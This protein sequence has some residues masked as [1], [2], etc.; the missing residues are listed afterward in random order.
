[1]SSGSK[2]FEKAAH[3]VIIAAHGPG[4]LSQGICVCGFFYF[5]TLNFDA[6]RK[7]V[8]VAAAASASASATVGV[9][10]STWNQVQY[11]WRSFAAPLAAPATPPHLRVRGN[12]PIDVEA[13]TSSPP[14]GRK[15]N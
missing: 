5:Y 8:A 7:S 2:N 13:Q 10:E 14:Q 12:V 6:T 3:G 15:C 9:L 11:V 4:D 1:M